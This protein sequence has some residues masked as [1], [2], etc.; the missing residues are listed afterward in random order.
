MGMDTESEGPELLLLSSPWGAPSEGPP[1]GIFPLHFL[2]AGGGFSCS[3]FRF[4]SGP[5]LGVLCSLFGTAPATPGVCVPAPVS[6]LL[7]LSRG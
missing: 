3:Y 6:G 5:V 7:T 4:P 1:Q 2:G